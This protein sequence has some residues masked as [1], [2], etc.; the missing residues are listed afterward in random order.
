MNSQQACQLAAFENSN[1]AAELNLIDKVA[2]LES[3]LVDAK[4]WLQAID[5]KQ[6]AQSMIAR[7][8]AE[9]EDMK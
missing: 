5:I 6:D 8:D 3:L 4:H 7:I 9:L 1:K 2:R